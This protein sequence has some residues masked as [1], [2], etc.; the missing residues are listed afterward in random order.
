MEEQIPAARGFSCGLGSAALTPQGTLVLPA[1]PR[2]QHTQAARR[3]GQLSQLLRWSYRPFARTHFASALDCPQSLFPS[4]L[5]L[6][7]LSQFGVVAGFS[8]QGD[9]GSLQK[10]GGTLEAL[11][12][13]SCHGAGVLSVVSLMVGAV[14]VM[15]GL[16]EA[17]A[18]AEAVLC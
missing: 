14:A 3:R 4:F 9:L 2:A 7:V 15:K 5:A 18:M 16:R 12:K 13:A 17:P 6:L 11:S 10:A 8:Q 1:L